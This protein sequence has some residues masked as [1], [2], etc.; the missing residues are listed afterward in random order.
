MWHSKQDLPYK[1]QFGTTKSDNF[2]F[3]L[4]FLAILSLAPV[5]EL[6]SLSLFIYYFMFPNT[7][8]QVESNI[9]SKSA[10][11]I[12]FLSSLNIT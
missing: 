2:V 8:K 4:K 9:Y 12:S 11:N 5:A 1:P 3:C 10:P 6:L 7:E